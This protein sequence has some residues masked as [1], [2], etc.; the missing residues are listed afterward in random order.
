MTFDTEIFRTER[1]RNGF[2]AYNCMIAINSEDK[3]VIA[4]DFGNTGHA[5]VLTDSEAEAF[6]KAMA[7]RFA[8]ATSP[9][10]ANSIPPHEPST[11]GNAYL[12][13]ERALRIIENATKLGE[14][15]SADA[16]DQITNLAHEAGAACNRMMLR[17]DFFADDL[18]F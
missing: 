16:I 2:D 12:A 17:R 3:L 4:V 7:N 6:W 9:T 13:S 14:S 15:L 11:C 18:P 10:G 8:P 5:M 1:H